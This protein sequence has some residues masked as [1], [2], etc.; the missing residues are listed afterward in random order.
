MENLY[1]LMLFGNWIIQYDL[2]ATALTA[3]FGSSSGH[4]RQVVDI[5]EQA[6]FHRIQY[7]VFR[8]TSPNLAPHIMDMTNYVRGGLLPNIP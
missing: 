1:A 8:G 2:G 3:S 5:L 7:S 4:Y 6:G